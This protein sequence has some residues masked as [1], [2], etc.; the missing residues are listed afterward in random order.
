MFPK[1][2][3]GERPFDLNLSRRRLVYAGRDYFVPTTAIGTSE[4]FSNSFISSSVIF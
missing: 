4:V 3:A 1:A 2:E